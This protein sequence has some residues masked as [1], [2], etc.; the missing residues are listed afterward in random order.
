MGLAGGPRSFAY[1]R[2]R[3]C[4]ALWTGIKYVVSCTYEDRSLC[5]RASRPGQRD[6][7]D[8]YDPLNRRGNSCLSSCL[9][10]GVILNAAGRLVKP[11][12]CL[13][14]IKTRTDKSLPRP[15]SAQGM[16][17]SPTGRS[18]QRHICSHRIP[19]WVEAGASSR[20]FPWAS[21]LV[22]QFA[23][24]SA[25]PRYLTSIWPVRPHRLG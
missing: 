11:R 20:L 17:H 25:R 7:C 4:G 6:S 2:R 22:Q 18:K 23:S 13:E 19:D 8:N 14:K 12:F 10:T 3:L 1:G 16:T 9:H 5:G 15:S 21:A 24:D